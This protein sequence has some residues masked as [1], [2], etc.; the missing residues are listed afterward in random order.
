MD[1]APHVIHIIGTEP[2][3]PRCGLLTNIVSDMIKELDITAEV[4][5]V[6]YKSKEAEAF[7]KRIGLE[8]GTA[9]DVARRM[10]RPIDTTRLSALLQG[11]NSMK[12]DD[13]SAYNTCNWSRELDEF[14]RPY[15]DAAPDVGIIM[16]PIL[17]I[18]GEVIHN[19]NVP[20]IKQVEKYLL[21]LT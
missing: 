12:N 13:Y 8:P 20:E 7:G 19:G 9:K 1:D 4:R 17:I 10:N 15:E 6:D 18:N 2:P 3:C 16:T 21:N 5:H 14:L 11:K